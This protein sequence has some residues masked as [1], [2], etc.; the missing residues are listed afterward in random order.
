MEAA[1]SSGT[2]VSYHISTRR[3]NPE[4][5]DLDLLLVSF[6]IRFTDDDN[7]DGEDESYWPSPHPALYSFQ[8]L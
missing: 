5:R 1:W 3:H 2:L 4:D 7:G 8:F 6:T